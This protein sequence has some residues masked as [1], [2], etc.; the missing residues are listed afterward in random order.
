MSLDVLKQAKK[1]IGVKQA[2][3]SVEKNKVSL[4]YIAEDADDRVVKPLREVCQQKNV[5][6]ETVPTMTELGK[7]CVIEVGAAAVAVLR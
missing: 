5:P 4:V 6:V 1:V 2:V 3:K 7:A